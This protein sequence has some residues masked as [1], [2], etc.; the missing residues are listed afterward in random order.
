MYL[1]VGKW[2]HRYNH[3]NRIWHF[4]AKQRNEMPQ[5]VE[6]KCHKTAEWYCGMENNG[7]LCHVF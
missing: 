4:T 7:Y 3:I 6:M 5:K 2:L 1:Y